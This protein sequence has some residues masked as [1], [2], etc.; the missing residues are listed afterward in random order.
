MTR[1]RDEARARLDR[2]RIDARTVPLASLEALGLLGLA[3][4]GLLYYRK[5]LLQGT[6]D[7][8][9]RGF[10]AKA[11]GLMDQLDALRQRHKEL[12]TTDPDFTAPLSGATLALYNEVEA[13]LNG[14]WDRW[15][16][17]MEVWDEAQ[18]LVRAGSGLAVKQTEEAKRLLEEGDIDEL[19]RRCNSCKERLDRLNQGHERARSDLKAGRDE[20]A[21]LR[22]SLIKAAR[23]GLSADPYQKEVATVETMLTE[24]EGLIEADPIGAEA[25]IVRSRQALAAVVA[26]SGQVLTR[27]GETRSAAAAIDE[28]AAAVAKLRSAAARIQSNSLMGRFVGASMVVGGLALLFGFL[29]ALMP[30]VVL[31]LGF[32]FTLA[33]LWVIWRI[34]ASWFGL[35]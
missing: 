21:A 32:V 31:V 12:P 28:L 15:L 24:A 22:K 13:E 1:V 8:Q 30:L 25:V 18:K 11:V 19:L 10:R 5:R 3:A 27:F 29:T 23:A 35:F 7:E 20:V 34:V 33:V 9:F 17:V 16:K 14:L 4:L 6:V 2:Q 26:R